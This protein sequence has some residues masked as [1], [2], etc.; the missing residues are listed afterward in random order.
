MFHFSLQEHKERFEHVIHHLCIYRNPII[1]QGEFES[2]NIILGAISILH[3]ALSPAIFSP[4]HYNTC[5]KKI[6]HSHKSF[7]CRETG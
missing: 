5:N 7:E 1:R 4:F 3:A 6:F 2:I